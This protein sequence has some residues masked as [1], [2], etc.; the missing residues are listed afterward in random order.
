MF[1]CQI[2]NRTYIHHGVLDDLRRLFEISEGDLVV[3]SLWRRA[4][5]DHFTLTIP[6]FGF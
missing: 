6:P 5:E 1:L 3:E 2:E 4:V